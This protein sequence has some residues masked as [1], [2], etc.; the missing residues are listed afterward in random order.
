MRKTG[1]IWL[2]ETRYKR[3]RLPGGR[4]DFASKPPVFK[5]YDGAP[6][7]M[8]EF[9][10]NPGLAPLDQCLKTRKSIRRFSKTPIDFR[11]LS[12]L[13]WAASGIREVSGGHAFRT[14]PSAGALYPIETYVIAGNIENVEQ[15]LHHY[16]V[17]DHS[18]ELME[19]G[20]LSMMAGSVALDQN[21]CLS[22]AAI[23]IFTAVWERS[24]W[25]YK[26]R[27]YRYVY[28]D[29][30]HMAQNLALAATGL[31]LGT[32]AIGAFYDEE[33]D[34]AL[35]LDSDEEGT[36]LMVVAGRP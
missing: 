15:G 26:Q 4:L 29:A 11:E 16:C 35:D 3:G 19:K 25:K 23:F 18:L 30:G 36:V 31:G 20:D 24:K 28:L 7:T 33:V 21:M 9:V 1:D 6:K 13:T 5:S 22:A 17:K 32:C 34:A 27:G 2:N 10:E 12:F 8:L 14:A